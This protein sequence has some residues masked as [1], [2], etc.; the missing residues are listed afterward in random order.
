V[1]H[2]FP[3]PII[4]HGLS[5]AYQLAYHWPTVSLASRW[6]PRWPPVGL[7]SGLP[8]GLA[9]VLPL[10]IPLAYPWPPYRWPTL[11]LPLAYPWPTLGLSL[12]L[13]LA[14]RTVGLPSA[15]LVYVGLSV[16][17]PVGLPLASRWPTIG[18]PIGLP[19]AYRTVGLPMAYRRPTA[20]PT[21]GLPLAYHWP[22]IAHGASVVHKHPTVGH[23]HLG[24]LA[25][26]LAAEHVSAGQHG[27]VALEGVRADWAQLRGGNPCLALCHRTPPCPPG[28]PALFRRPL[29]AP[30]WWPHLLPFVA[31]Q[32]GPA[33]KTQV[34]KNRRA[35][36]SAPEP[37]E[38]KQR[39]IDV[40]SL[41]AVRGK[42]IQH[43]RRR[44]AKK[45]HKKRTLR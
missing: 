9:L 36:C 45:K 39:A 3:R 12:G 38:R 16:G 14:Y 18:L 27:E 19:L 40:R 26:T 29:A 8:S 35:L 7:P 44:R 5:L 34:K 30:M 33:R 23:K 17:F 15:S 13:P 42:W 43:L 37:W 10:G 31:P 2:H 25:L 6:P 41:P 11:G 28:P 20:G 4:A 32:P 1:A 22:I 24:L 21:V